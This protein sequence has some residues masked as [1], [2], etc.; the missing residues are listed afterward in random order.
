MTLLKLFIQIV[1][2]C[3]LYE[4]GNALQ[5]TLSIPIPGS[6]IG[7]IL[8]F[9]LLLSGIVKK[10]WLGTGAHFLIRYLSLLLAPSVIG[11]MQYEGFL[12][13][14]GL[15]IILMILLN[16]VLIMG[17]SGWLSQL[18]IRHLERKSTKEEEAQ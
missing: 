14:Q 12:L 18:L 5:R 9:L 3:C 7:M 2:L 4:I 6:I 13:H 8:L 17:G 11:V 1:G 10:Q 15:L 16:T